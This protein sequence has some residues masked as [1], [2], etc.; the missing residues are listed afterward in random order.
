MG[1]GFWVLGSGFRGFGV[2]GFRGFGV[3]G[4]RGFGVSGFKP[5]TLNT[6]TSIAGPGACF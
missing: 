4:F 6:D 3:S 1:F 2:S 5:E